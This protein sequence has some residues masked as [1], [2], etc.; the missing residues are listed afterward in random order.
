M[1]FC[2]KCRIEYREGFTTCSDCDVE[3]V[4]QLAP[5]PE[6][7]EH[8]DEPLETVF[9]T[10]NSIEVDVVKGVLDAAG[11][12]CYVTPDALRNAYGPLMSG[13]DHSLRRQEIMVLESDADRARAVIEQAM[14]S[15]LQE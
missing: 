11:I 4:A 8:E 5:E 10:S 15:G 1:P 6:K 7:G 3:L 14:E 2:P 13:V 12:P 9:I